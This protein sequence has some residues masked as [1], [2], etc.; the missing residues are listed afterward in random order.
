MASHGDSGVELDVTRANHGVWLL[1]VRSRIFLLVF[2]SICGKLS[3]V[4]MLSG[5]MLS[6]LRFQG[7]SNTHCVS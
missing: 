1:K 4:R 3:L 2:H 6:E 5:K 7:D